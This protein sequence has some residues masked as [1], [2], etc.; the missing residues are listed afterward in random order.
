MDADEEWEQEEFR[1]CGEYGEEESV[2]SGR[3]PGAVE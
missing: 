3:H 1:I 2:Q